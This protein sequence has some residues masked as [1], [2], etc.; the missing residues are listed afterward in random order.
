MPKALLFSYVSRV[1]KYLGSPDGV[2]FRR[3][4]MSGKGWPFERVVGKAVIDVLRL[5]RLE[6][7]DAVADEVIIRELSVVA[8]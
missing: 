2:R 5:S 4:L 1:R 8:A 3:E 7:I 6:D